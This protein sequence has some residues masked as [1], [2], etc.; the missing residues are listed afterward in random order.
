MKIFHY[1]FDYNYENCW[2][3]LIVLVPLEIGMNTLPRSYRLS[4][5]N[6]N[7]VAT[8][9]DKTKNFTKTADRLLQCVL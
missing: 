8:L 1:I 2:Q 3:I 4:N 9:P 7:Y 6:P 5:F